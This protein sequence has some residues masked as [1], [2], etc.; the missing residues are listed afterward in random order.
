MRVSATGA[1][2]YGSVASG[3]FLTGNVRAEGLEI[4]GEAKLDATGGI[5]GL[6]IERIYSKDSIDL[7]GAVSRRK[8]GGY[9]IAPNGPYLNASP[10]MDGFLD[11]SGAGQDTTA[12]VGGPGSPGPTYDVQTNVQTLKTPAKPPTAQRRV[13]PHNHA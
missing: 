10:Y 12:P 9:R 11:M 2:G 3:A 7:H 4:T 5:N 8:D 1:F 13:S 6:E